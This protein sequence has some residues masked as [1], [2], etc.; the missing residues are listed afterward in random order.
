MFPVEQKPRLVYSI[1][2]GNTDQELLRI[3]TD[4][5]NNCILTKNNVYDGEP[6]WSPDGTR[7]V[8]NSMFSSASY[9]F[10]NQ[11]YIMNANGENIIKLTNDFSAVAA[12]D[13]SP[14][15]KK[16]VFQG[17]VR[18]KDYYQLFVINVDGTNIVNLT[19][20]PRNDTKA[21][22]SPDGQSIVLISG[23]LYQYG[24]SSD[25]D[26]TVNDE[27][28]VMDANGGNLRQITTNKVQDDFPSWSPDGQWLAFVR[29]DDIYV[30]DKDGKHV[31]RVAR[32]YLNS[33]A[34]VWTPDGS[35]VGFVAFDPDAIKFV[36][37]HT[38][39]IRLV[40]VPDIPINV[41]GWWPTTAR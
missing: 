6:S 41:A 35:E 3:N 13:W 21:K 38:G 40:L 19:N 2:P 4:G 15:G 22:W 9:G 12:P 11:L 37:I 20:V 10:E 17:V 28:F 18:G 14:D 8:Y 36:N 32:G 5:T 33:S 16:I 1:D 25:T 26:Q 30:M 24:L 27:I 23:P 7:I 39:Q 29:A 34:P 31:R